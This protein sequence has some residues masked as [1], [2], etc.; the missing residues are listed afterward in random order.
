MKRYVFVLSAVMLIAAIVF[1]TQISG[2]T[3]TVKEG[4]ILSVNDIASDPSAY[5]GV[6]IVTGVVADKSRFKIPENVFLMVETSEAKICK[7]TSCARFYLQVRYDGKIPQQWDEVNVTG[8]FVENAR[9]FAANKVEVL[10]H[11]D[12]GGK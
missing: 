10:R 9:I 7:Q 4:G 11:L 6:I 1:T 5:N 2:K 8:S 3:K 12:F